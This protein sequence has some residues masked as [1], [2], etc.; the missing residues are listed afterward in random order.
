LRIL[1]GSI[2]FVSPM[3]DI[4]IGRLRSLFLFGGK[5][6]PA[7]SVLV[8]A[9]SKHN[10]GVYE[11]YEALN[12]Q[13]TAC[14]ATHRD[15]TNDMVCVCTPPRGEKRQ[16]SEDNQLQQKRARTSNQLPSYVRLT[17]RRR[18]SASS[19]DST[20]TTPSRDQQKRRARVTIRSILSSDDVD[21]YH[22]GKLTNDT[23]DTPGCG[24]VST[25]RQED[26]LRQIIT[27]ADTAT[28]MQAA[29]QLL[30]VDKSCA[31]PEIIKELRTTIET[32]SAWE[33]SADLPG[34][35]V[36]DRS[37]AILIDL[38]AELAPLALPLVS[39]KLFFICHMSQGIYCVVVA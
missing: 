29:L 6:A 1:S 23:L 20:K 38:A 35:G 9:L 10:N 7:S 12:P 18:P 8:E 32:L 15:V 39:W 37:I 17:E 28:T 16:R 2:K 25:T 11:A 31:S 19:A 22:Q 5:S 13:S 34:T 26:L 24:R 3:D 36:C 27:R 30:N 14:I 21:E 4:L 33:A